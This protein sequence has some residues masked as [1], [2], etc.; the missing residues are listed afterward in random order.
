MRTGGCP[1]RRA[2]RPLCP[3]GSR[4]GGPARQGP[5]RPAPSGPHGKSRL[6][7]ARLCGSLESRR[8]ERGGGRASVGAW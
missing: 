1:R 3:R 5:R 8:G 6:P 2:P 4:G 7:H